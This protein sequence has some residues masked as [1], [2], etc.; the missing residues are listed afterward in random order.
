MTSKNGTLFSWATQGSSS[1]DTV[2]EY[3]HEPC[4]VSVI[5]SGRGAGRGEGGAHH[6]I[7]HAIKSN[8]VHAAANDEISIENLF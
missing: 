2:E 7:V 4:L 6:E 3:R 5:E 1:S 8:N